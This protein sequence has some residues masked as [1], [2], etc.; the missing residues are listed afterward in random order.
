MWV[1]SSVMGGNCCSDVS[2][3]VGHPG[4]ALQ[5]VLGPLHFSEAEL[6]PLSLAFRTV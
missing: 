4:V 3:K 6:A 1:I 2:I 5:A